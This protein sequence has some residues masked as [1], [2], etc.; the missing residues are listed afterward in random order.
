MY[1]QNSL[2]GG[3][4]PCGDVS[5]QLLPNKAYQAR[6]NP[7][8]DALAGDPREI[9]PVVMATS[10]V[11]WIPLTVESLGV[12]KIGW[13]NWAMAN[14]W[15]GWQGILNPYVTSVLAGGPP[16]T[17]TV[18]L[19]TSQNGPALGWTVSVRFPPVSTVATPMLV[20][21]TR[22]DR[23][24]N[25]FTF[26][27]QIDA[28]MNQCDSI[29]VLQ[30]A[31]GLVGG[32]NCLPFPMM[33]LSGTPQAVVGGATVAR[34]GQKVYTGQANTTV[35]T[36][37]LTE[38][39]PYIRQLQTQHQNLLGEWVQSR[40]VLVG[41]MDRFKR[42]EETYHQRMND[43]SAGRNLKQTYIPP[44]Q[45]IDQQDPLILAA[46]N[47]VGKRAISYAQNGFVPQVYSAPR[48]QPHGQYAAYY[49][50]TGH[51]MAM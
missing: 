10:G 34:A 24:N 50:G 15:E 25:S 8:M 18:N 26:Q 28:P 23:S 42:M 2:G 14:L 43:L 1:T 49:P 39:N 4:G 44:A 27:Y 3:C 33:D 19:A 7:I 46:K 6:G 38:T 11:G 30:F 22:T 32:T 9:L 29:S 40:S 17:I 12:S 48:F 37:F 20:A 45:Q 21:D 36:G 47:G 51:P 13:L 35:V 16:A 31:H 41:L 5:A